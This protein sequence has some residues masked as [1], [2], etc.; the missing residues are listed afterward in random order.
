MESDRRGSGNRLGYTTTRS[1]REQRYAAT[2]DS[3]VAAPKIVWRFAT[4]IDV[5]NET[6][7]TRTL[8]L[9]VP[10]WPGHRAGQHVTYDSQR[11]N[12]YQTDVATLSRP[13]RKIPACAHRRAP[14]RWGSLTNLSVSCAP[15][16][17]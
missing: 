5:V 8:T 15:A 2:S 9:D 14:R 4:V 10:G 17:S 6:P 16:I 12:G 7:E 13:H 3:V 1:W 11:K